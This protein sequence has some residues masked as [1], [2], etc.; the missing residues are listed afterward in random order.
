[1]LQ[2]GLKPGESSF[3]LRPAGLE[4]RTAASCWQEPRRD[5]GTCSGCVPIR[6][7]P[8]GTQ[9]PQLTRS[10]ADCAQC[11]P[12]S[13]FVVGFQSSGP[14]GST[15]SAGREDSEGCVLR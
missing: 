9:V 2:S 1:M 7:D 14:A 15:G 5:I 6:S 11:H 4:A 13:E 3:G 8:A 12:T 10:A